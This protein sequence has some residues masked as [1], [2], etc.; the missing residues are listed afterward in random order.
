[1]LGK[2]ADRMEATLPGNE[3]ERLAA[4]HDHSILDTAPE[5]EFDDLVR[6]AA[7]LCG[8][9]IA[10]V[11]LID[12]HRQWFKA[13]LGLPI[14]ETPRADAFCAHTIL[15]SDILVVPDAQADPRFADNPLV[16]GDPNIRFY[17]GVPLITEEGLALGSLCII[18]RNPR[19]FTP[20]QEELLRLLA[21]QV[22]GHLKSARRLAERE[23]LLAEREE[24][25]AEKERMAAERE[26][27][28][29]DRLRLAS[30][31]ETCDD[32]VYGRTLDGIITSWNA[33][34]Q[35]LYGYS[36][37]EMLGHEV[38]LLVPPDRL[39]ELDHIAAGIRR[40]E[41]VLPLET[42]RLTK[43]GGRVDVSL[44]VSLITDSGGRVTGA[45]MIARDITERKQ[46]EAALEAE[47]EFTHALLESLEEG[48]VACDAGGTLT[49]FNRA[50][51]EF[52]GLPE[53]PLPPEA[54][55]GHFSL[56]EPDGLT[57]LRMRDIPLFRAFGGEVVRDAEMVIAPALGRTRTLLASG[58]PILGAHGQKLGAVVAMHD[59]TKRRQVER[60]LARLAAIVDSSEE[61]ILAATLDGTILSWNRGAEKLY[62]YAAAEMIGRHVS[63]L[64]PPG[65]V[66]PLCAVVTRLVRSEAVEPMELSRVR[67]DGTEFHASL[68]FSPIR[69]AEGN[70]VGLSCIARDITSRKLAEAALAGSRAE[71]QESEERLKCLT[72]AAF[73]GIAISRDGVLADVNPAFAEMF[74]CEQPA[75]MVGTGAAHLCALESRAFVLERISS[76]DER[77][78]EAVLQRRDG[79]TFQAELR[80]R[81]IQ[82]NGLPARVTAVRDISERKEMERALGESQAFTQAVADNSASLIYVFDL[83][84]GA[85]IYANRGLAEFWGYTPG[86]IRALGSELVP[87][88]IHPDDMLFLL[89]HGGD[90]AVLPDGEVMEFETR[91]RHADGGWRWLWHREVVFKRHP[92]G[93]PWQ[94]LGNAQDITERKHAEEQI[95][96]HAV[97]LEFQKMELEKANDEL[98]AL[99]TTDGLTGLKN[100]RAFQERLAEEVS[101]A[102]RYGL[103]LSLILLDVDSFKRYND[104]HGHPAG[105]VV[106]KAVA[107]VLQDCARDT[108]LV[109]RYGGEE[110]VIVLPQTEAD[111]AVAFAERLRTAVESYPWLLQS[112]TAS[113]GAASL[114]LGEEASAD[115]IARAD[116]ALYRSKAEGRNCVT[117]GTGGACLPGMLTA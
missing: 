87:R 65:Q 46:S 89:A 48:I 73:E 111:G 72:D 79:T 41:R 83:D 2:K 17:A 32:A 21:R 107:Q 51:R 50:S 97:I 23:L 81:M 86:E 22:A 68:S 59:V 29:A 54:W 91:C 101:R 24:L 70:I 7:S 10:A 53:Q 115:L 3:Q 52:H 67:R 15:Q 57:P 90:F 16:T 60:E 49:L 31:V 76:G 95:K 12:E 26:R 18:D 69:D 94:V 109:A 38:S 110:F 39:D 13:I 64:T 99:A 98:E 34:A 77:P 114:H 58:R 80:A 27:V 47:R 30:I 117:H 106:L 28:E 33:G 1:M 61:A 4:L 6:L 35:G 85:N 75:E 92:D 66:S 84:T 103:P 108:D 25:L 96:D 19:Q 9:P 100:H 78:Y 43:A 56:F 8:V 112:V 113:F 44:H 63:F 102:S 105:D 74:G 62:G 14:S 82:R 20:E 104:T 71:L 55:A 5:R 37:A 93:R 116:R 11:S 36:A 45:S 42:V 88:I 40:G